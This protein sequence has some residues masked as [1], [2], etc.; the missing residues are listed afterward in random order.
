MIEAILPTEVGAAET[1]GD[2]L[3]EAL[4][5]EE[6]AALSRAPGPRWPSSVCRAR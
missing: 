4:F 1:F 3:D 6:E 2:V 5:P